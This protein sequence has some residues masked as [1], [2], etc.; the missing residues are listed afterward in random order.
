MTETISRFQQV[1]GMRTHLL[2]AGEGPAVVLLH[3][4]EFGGCAEASWGHLMAPIA[5][6]GY[7][8]IAPDLLGFGKTDKVVD[9]A[10]PKGRR[11]RHLA[12]LLD[13]L[14]L[15]RPAMVGNSMGGTYLAQMLAAE[16]P[17]IEAGVAVFVSA[18]GMVP[19][20]DARR[21]ILDYDLTEEGMARILAVMMHSPKL[22]QDRDYVQWRHR[23]SLEPGAWQCAESARLRPPGTA[24]GGE[25]GKPD[26]TVYERI[27][28]PTLV[29]AGREDPLRLP[30]YATELAERLPDSRL[31]V[32]P[33]CGH[34]PN[35]E[36]A[37]RF[38]A[39]LVDFLRE[40]YTG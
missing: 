9:F 5:A 18:G 2:E 34:L 25:F 40:R 36:H 27:G 16:K 3:S 21:A 24:V 15:D 12:E 26:R 28:I 17:L 19:D 20:N 23:L 6:A 1:G 8:V 38:A 11:F 13:D 7:R 29:I 33:E 32:Y 14:G 39:D 31:L 4:G 35:V 10:D 37:E 22:S 30:G